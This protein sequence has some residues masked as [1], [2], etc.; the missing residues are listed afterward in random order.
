VGSIKEIFSNHRKLII[1][2]IV[3]HII[4]AVFSVGYYHVD[5]HFQILEFTSMKLG[6]AE[7]NSLP[8]EYQAHLRPALQPAIAFMTIKAISFIGL[9]NPF[10]HAT[11]LRIISAILALYCLY[12]L[13]ISLLPQIKSEFLIKWLIFLSLFIWFLPYLH[14][15]FSSENWSGIFF[16][17]GFALINMQIHNEEDKDKSTLKTVFLGAIL[18]LAFVLRFQIGILIGGY[19]LWLLFI[20]KET[21]STV[22]LLSVG[23]VLFILIG[24]LVDYWYYGEWT[25]T[26]W[27]Y[28]K[29]N[30]L[31]GKTSEFG[32]EPW[33]FY[34]EEIVI[35]GVP[36]YSIVIILSSMIIWIKFP[37]H[38]ITWISIPYI[39]IHSL[40]GH[41]ELRFLFSLVYIIP[42]IIVFSLQ[43]I[44]NDRKFSKIKDLLYVSKKPLYILFML[45]N[46]VLLIV[47]CF[48]PA[49]MHIYLYQHIYSTYDPG[50]T[51]II[52]IGRGPYSRAVPVNFYK[53][54]EFQIKTFS[55]K[56]EMLE[57]M[58]YSNKNMLFA[59]RE[60][61][62]FPELKEFYCTP[63]YRNLPPG[64][65]YYNIN[66]WVERTPFWTLYE[67]KKEE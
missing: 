65:K 18:G 52:S 38:M 42:F 54:K 1:V 37:K 26:A 61:E 7:E 46:S 19:F 3:I 14:V 16:W 23:T 21:W 58:F 12:L 10:F 59:T 25:V 15:R 50:K 35:K 20:K 32:L 33:W 44:Q 5:E 56:A 51:E 30:L 55:D 60:S 24:I 67:C 17:I 39:F 2:G 4:T 31:E 66:N 43:V 47:L 34:I 6:L 63:V 62:L 64:V 29:V 22:F 48:K 40:I 13:I 8:W 45:I 49:D 28:F 27:N 57:H 41:K 53:K 9:D 11:L 36:P